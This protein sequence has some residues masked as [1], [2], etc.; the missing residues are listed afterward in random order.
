MLLLSRSRL[1]NI[2]GW[3]EWL[4]GSSRLLCDTP[5]YCN[6]CF[7]LDLIAFHH[8]FRFG[9]FLVFH[10]FVVKPN[11]AGFL[12]IRT[13]QHFLVF[14]VAFPFISEAYSFQLDCSLQC[15]SSVLALPVA[16]PFISV[17]YVFQLGWPLL[18]FIHFSSSNWQYSL[19]P[20][21]AS[22]FNSAIF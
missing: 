20:L 7:L 15:R 21:V 1:L 3:F 6:S 4:C 16:F 14:I 10:N 9:T 18:L 11:S 8:P 17:A 2:V 22:P 19:T 12:K 13:S 5:F